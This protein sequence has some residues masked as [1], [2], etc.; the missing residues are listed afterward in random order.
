MI[1]Q[2]LLGLLAL[3]QLA[4]AIP[5]A[6]TGLSTAAKSAGKKYFGSA[7]DNPELTNTAYV[8]ELSNVADFSQLTAENSMKWDAIEPN[9]GQFTFS[10]GDQILQLAQK[11]GQLMRGHNCV[12]HEQLPSWVTNTQWTN[13]TLTAALTNHIT[14]LIGH[15]KG[16]MYSWDVVNEP[17]NE[18]GSLFSSVFTEFIGPAYIPIALKTARA[19]DPSTKLYINEFNIEFT[20]AK[21][22][23]MLNLVKQLKQEGVPVDGIGFQCHFIVGEVPTSFQSILQQFTALGVEVAITELD[24]RMT[25]PETTALLQQQ[26][27]D[28][29]TVINA[30]RSVAN[31]VGVTVWDYTD[32]FSWIPGAFPGMG[33]ACPFDSNFNKKPAYQGILNGWA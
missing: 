19:A 8:A 24:I 12:W 4:T 15:Y 18:D 22:T 1:L 17:F 32:E 25:L 28:Y 30:C 5:T 14:N 21:A 29:Q 26:Q 11:N 13:A 16:D 33:D 2:P 6:S 23:A 10:Q 9:Q 3:L 27:T 7:T 20:G 31:C